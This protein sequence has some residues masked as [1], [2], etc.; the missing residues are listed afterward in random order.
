MYIV[1]APHFVRRLEPERR[2]TEKPEAT[3]SETLVPYATLTWPPPLLETPSLVSERTP[4]CRIERVRLFVKST[5]SCASNREPPV[6]CNSTSL[7]V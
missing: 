4:A 5:L 6:D 1:P 3:D 7:M 2:A